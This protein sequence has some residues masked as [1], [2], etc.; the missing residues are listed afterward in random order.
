MVTLKHDLRWF[1]LALCK[2]GLGLAVFAGIC[3]LIYE[4]VGGYRDYHRFP[5][6]GRMI[7]V[8]GHK[9]NL[10]CTG[11]GEPTVVLEAPS[12]GISA[13]WRP[14]QEA[15][16]SF[17]QVCSY[18]RAGFGW[19]DP[20]P[21][22]RSSRQIA[23]ELH[24]LLKSA[25][26]NPPYV[27]V[28]SSAGGFHVR[29]YAGRFPAEVLGVVLVDS[30]HPDQVSKLHLEQNPTGQYRMWE[31]F[32][33][34][35]HGLGILRFGLRRDPRPVAFPMDAWNEVLY[36]RER[37][38]SYRTLLRE[39]EAWA[40]SASEVRASDGLGSKPLLVLTGS[41]GADAQWRTLWIDGLQADLVHL[42]LRGRQIL[43]EKSGHGIQF[44]AP[45]AV[46]S[47]IQDIWSLVR[48]D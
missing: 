33:P 12:T 48:R 38:N 14:V 44:E 22:P 13:T 31:P 32:L 1:S 6:K 35:T 36:L 19:S 11:H 21:R 42:S 40:E 28:G 43:V 24:A 30:S 4:A 9:I 5:N 26:I 29:A 7:S 46:I 45:G 16:S 8:D 37:P 41:M 27:F 47:A 25:R 34:L 10:V 18:D 17:T 23:L 15:V 39:G 3:G 2:F 20:G